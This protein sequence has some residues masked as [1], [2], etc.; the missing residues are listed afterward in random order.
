MIESVKQLFHRTE[1]RLYRLH[2]CLGFA[3][4]TANHA[5]SMALYLALAFFMNVRS[6]RSATSSHRS[7]PS[8][9]FAPAPTHT[10]TGLLPLFS[11]SPHTLVRLS[12]ASGSES[13]MFVSW[14]PRVARLSWLRSRRYPVYRSRAEEEATKTSTSEGP[15]GARENSLGSVTPSRRG[16]WRSP[17]LRRGA[18]VKR[19]PRKSG[20]VIRGRDC[21]PSVFLQRHAHSVPQTDTAAEIE[22]SF[23][24]LPSSVRKH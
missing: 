20:W 16:E 22:S 4:V 1:H 10:T 2:A 17:S 7:S 5:R 8:H 12:N 18:P 15:H 23:S 14:Y 9:E 24:G 21:F 3:A 11:A 6:N 19:R 13:S